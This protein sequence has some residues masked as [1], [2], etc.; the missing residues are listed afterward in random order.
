M[1]AYQPQVINVSCRSMSPLGGSKLKSLQAAI[2]RHIPP[3]GM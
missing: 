2:K 1:M 3:L